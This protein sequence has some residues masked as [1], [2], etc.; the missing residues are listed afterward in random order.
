MDS[1]ALW[2]SEVREAVRDFLEADLS[3]LSVSTFACQLGVFI[4]GIFYESMPATRLVLVHGNQDYL[5][6]SDEISWIEDISN[7]VSCVDS[8]GH[9]I[10]AF[11]LECDLDEYYVKCAA[12]IKI[13]NA[14]FDGNNLFVFK[15]QDAVAL[16]CKRKPADIDD[17]FC[18]S[19]PLIP[20]KL[21]NNALGMISEM[22]QSEIEEFGDVIADY[23]SSTVY[24]EEEEKPVSLASIED[25]DDLDAVFQRIYGFDYQDDVDWA[26]KLRKEF[27][28][29]ERNPY[30]EARQELRNVGNES[31]DTSYDEL[32]RARLAQE[33]AEKVRWGEDMEFENFYEYEDPLGGRFSHD[34]Y[35]NA[36]IMLQELMAEDSYDDED[37]EI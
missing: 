17:N 12:V 4:R 37:E 24:E 8:L 2:E 35:G 20:G 11:N 13:Y 31:I 28:G 5:A 3:F 15:T 36:E 27:W 34:A 23:A 33:N 10:F 7:V 6:S 18:V 14:A 19:M 9:K 29:D 32:E 16:G 25:T 21:S 1:D 30:Q 26:A 22:V